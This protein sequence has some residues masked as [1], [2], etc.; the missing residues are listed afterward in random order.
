MEVP[1][2]VKKSNI[3]DQ[4]VFVKIAIPKG[5][6]VRI[7]D[8]REDQIIPLEEYNHTSKK[9]RKFLDEHGYWNKEETAMTFPRDEVKYFNHSCDPNVINDEGNGLDRDIAARDIAAGEELTYDYNI[10]LK[11]EEDRNHMRWMKCNCGAKPCKGV[12]AV[13]D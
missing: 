9:Q 12:I 5:T 8:G 1:V 7:N 6:V 3:C 2:E 10:F 13:E 11:N 4:G